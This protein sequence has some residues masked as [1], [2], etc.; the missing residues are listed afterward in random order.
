MTYVLLDTNIFLHCQSFDTL[1]LKEIVGATDEVSVLLPMQVLRELEKKKGN[2]DNGAI[3]RR[4]RSVCAK[5]GKMLLEDEKTSLRIVTCETPPKEEFIPEL[6]ME[7]ADDVILMTAIRFM[8]SH[9]GNLVVVSLDVPMLLKA[10]QLGFNYVIMPE[11][12]VLSNKQVDKEKQQL[13]EELNR[14]KSRLPAPVVAFENGEKIIHL[15]RYV[16][17][18]IIVDDYLSQEERDFCLLQKEA[19][20]SKKRFYN[21][22]LFVFNHGTAPTDVFTAQLDLSKLRTCRTA[23]DVY[24]MTVPRLFQT[25]DEKNK[26]WDEVED[27][28]E[29]EP[30]RSFSIIRRDDTKETRTELKD[31]FESITQGLNRVICYFVIDLLEAKSGSIDWELNIPALP[32][33]VKG[34]LSVVID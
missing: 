30:V 21:L 7:I 17:K 1:P 11:K 13:K 18:E 19:E 3:N 12:Y 2:R 31:E 5:L 23:H 25:E 4:A 16:P 27:W 29:K 10:K 22:A 20:E 9:T 32:E 26:N 6:L 28:E 8:S 33:P 24:S 14:L 34:T 15:K